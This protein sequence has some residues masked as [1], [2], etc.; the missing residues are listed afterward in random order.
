MSPTALLVVARNSRRRLA[1]VR[2]TLRRGEDLHRDNGILGDE[3]SPAS[4][5]PWLNRAMC[6]ARGRVW[7]LCNFGDPELTVTPC[8][9]GTRRWVGRGAPRK[10]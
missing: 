4:V 7:T 10:G 6:R 9:G 5:D 1:V 3:G 8:A 2:R